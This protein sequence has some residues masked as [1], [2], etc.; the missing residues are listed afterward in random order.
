MEI[1]NLKLVLCAALGCIGGLI[2]QAFGGWNS[3]IVTL[4][5]FMAVDY[6]MGSGSGRRCAGRNKSPG[7]GDPGAAG[8]G[9]AESRTCR[10]RK[11]R[12][13]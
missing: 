10:D 11:I 2:A 12:R 4:L 8:N 5:A 9:A 1:S 3:G 13:I 6:I 7:H